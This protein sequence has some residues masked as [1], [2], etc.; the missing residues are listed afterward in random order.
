MFQLIIN[1]FL[2]TVKQNIILKEK[3]KI[4]FSLILKR[5]RSLLEVPQH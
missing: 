4:I 5:I 3:F 1:R 2:E